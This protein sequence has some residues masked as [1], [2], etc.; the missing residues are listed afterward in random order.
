M[1]DAEGAR[2]LD[3]DVVILGAG[4][5]GLTAGLYV[6]RAKLRCLLLGA[7]PGGKPVL[8]EEV[9]NYPGFPGG[10]P[11]AQLM[12]GMVSQADDS[13]IVRLSE[14][15]TRISFEPDAI[16]VQVG[17][18]THSSRALIVATGSDPI[19][20]GVPGEEEFAGN[21]VYYC[22]HCDAAVFQ[23][24]AKARACVVGGG[25]TALH[26]ALYLTRYAEEVTIVYHGDALKGNASVR[27][28]V[29]AHP[30]IRVELHRRVSA[31]VGED[32]HVEALRLL[33]TE[34]GRALEQETDGV[35]VGIGQRANSGLVRGLVDLDEA[36]F[37][38][39]NTGLETSRRGVFAAGD[40]TD[41]PFRQIV[42]AAGDGATAANSAIRFLQG[43]PT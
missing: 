43:E 38:R 24:L 27:D 4:P 13:G 12:L 15:A 23:F 36:G 11:G 30:K 33:D 16:Q 37:I 17:D 14:N 28:A 34:S 8:Y 32:H 25:D 19:P 2:I 22:A 26:T 39:V 7:Q 35:F 5:A 29:H 31:V 3:P 42:T 10:V 18:R 6:G 21:G 40:V 9:A 41:K 1:C 20:L